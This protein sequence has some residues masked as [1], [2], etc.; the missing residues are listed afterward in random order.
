MACIR[1]TCRY[2]RVPQAQATVE[3]AWGTNESNFM[4]ACSAIACIK[5]SLRHLS[6]ARAPAVLARSWGLKLSICC[7]AE[8]QISSS[9]PSRGDHD[10]VANAHRMLDND[11]G[12]SS[13]MR[14]RV[15]SIRLLHPGCRVTSR[16]LA[17]WPET[18]LDIFTVFA[19]R[20]TQVETFTPFIVGP[21][22]A[23]SPRM[24]STVAQRN[25]A[26]FVRL[27][28]AGSTGCAGRTCVVCTFRLVSREPR[29]ASAQTKQAAKS[30]PISV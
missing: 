6:E 2:P 30:T 17:R 13:E 28:T 5:E 3:T 1:A 7:I 25:I 27:A 14:E 24:S 21:C 4:S 15:K 22:S 8:S 18:H 26:A 23:A 19:T 20:Y 11:C 10:S 29:T 16:A 9:K 12:F